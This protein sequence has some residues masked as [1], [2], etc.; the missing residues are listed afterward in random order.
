MAGLSTLLWFILILTAVFSIGNAGLKENWIE[1]I[2][3]H[4]VTDPVWW[5]IGNLTS[6]NFQVR[7]CGSV[8]IQLEAKGKNKSS[9]IYKIGIGHMRFG[10]KIRK[11][12][13]IYKP[14][15]GKNPWAKTYGDD[16]LNCSEFRSFWI[17]WTDGNVKVGT[18]VNEKEGELVL[19]KMD[20]NASRVNA[21]IFDSVFGGSGEW[22]VERHPSVAV[23]DITMA[24]VLAVG[25]TNHLIFEVKTCAVLA[26]YIQDTSG[27][28]SILISLDGESND[29]AM[30]REFALAFSLAKLKKKLLTCK[31]YEPFWISW[32]KK[33]VKIGTGSIVG[34]D[35]LMRTDFMGPDNK[36]FDIEIIVLDHYSGHLKLNAT[37]C[38]VGFWYHPKFKSCYN[39]VYATRL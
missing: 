24:T 25:E 8:S 16:F 6:V 1:I 2:T 31:K 22:R 33:M 12:I 38:P 30:E 36:K 18:G 10:R 9:T 20:V 21:V 37:R 7:T 26:I 3:E 29:N 4:P 15:E 35:T 39:F 34:T 14:L 23:A 27:E 13:E 32:S 28:Q 19:K 17:S 11:G 5:T